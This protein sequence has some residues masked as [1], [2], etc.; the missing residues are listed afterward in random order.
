[1]QVQQLRYFIC[2]VDKHSFTE[3][4]KE[5]FVTQ[6]ALSMQIKNLEKEL[7]VT[8][9]NRIGRSFEVTPAG[10]LLYDRAGHILKEVEE[11]T[12]KVQRVNRNLGS[13][14]R[15]GLLSS[16]DKDKMP[17][18]LKELVLNRTGLELSIIYGSHD[19]LYEQFGNGCINAFVSDGQR[20]SGSESFSSIK[21]FSSKMYAEISHS[22]DIPHS[23]VSKLKLDVDELNKLKLFTV[24]EEEHLLDEQFS[25]IQMLHL[26]NEVQIEAVSSIAEGRKLILQR[27][28]SALIIDRSLLRG[29]YQA[30]NKT[31]RYEL[32]YQNKAVKK[33][34]C[35]YARKNINFNELK[36]ICSILTEMGSK[37]GRVYNSDDLLERNLSNNRM[38]TD[39][40]S[41]H[42]LTYTGHQIPL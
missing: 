20:L 25:L 28:N 4:A 21:L 19:E 35:L 15:L 1:M 3:A 2:L 27:P 42:V 32:I 39:D 6:P 12:E 13:T 33:P 30:S 40:T 29:D 10:K 16:M 24:C 11:L 23:G 26:T 36:E 18:R 8:L 34:L 9:I 7:D 41:S 31:F 22:T 38:S 14:L 17:G 37:R 5:C